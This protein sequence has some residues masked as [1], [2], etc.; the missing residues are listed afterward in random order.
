MAWEEPKVI[1]NIEVE[2]CSLQSHG[3]LHREGRRARYPPH[4]GLSG[5][6]A[7]CNCDMSN[8]AVWRSSC[9]INATSILL[10]KGKIQYL[11][12]KYV[13]FSI[14]NTSQ[15]TQGDLVWAPDFLYG[16]YLDDC[17]MVSG[18][19]CTDFLANQFLSISSF[20]KH[21]PQMSL[22]VLKF[23]TKLWQKGMTLASLKWNNEK[24]YMCE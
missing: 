17:E 4:P 22:C 6:F 14:C 2:E 7:T 23:R 15:R 3:S 12:I 16:N 10:C 13:F 20:A 24:K 8:S 11:K 9:H 19:C 1:S 21:I 18:L 5:T